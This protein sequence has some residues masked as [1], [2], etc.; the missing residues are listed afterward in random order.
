MEAKSCKKQGRQ[1]RKGNFLRKRSC[2][3]LGLRGITK[4]TFARIIYSKNAGKYSKYMTESFIGQKQ[5]KV[6]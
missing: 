5:E 4:I 3:H 2:L 6:E 1:V